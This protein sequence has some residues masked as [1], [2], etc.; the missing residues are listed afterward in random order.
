MVTMFILKQK[1]RTL[2]DKMIREKRKA[3]RLQGMTPQLIELGVSELEDI[4]ERLKL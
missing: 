4:K 3:M 2:L 1:A